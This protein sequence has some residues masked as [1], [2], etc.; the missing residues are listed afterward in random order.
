MC[1]LKSNKCLSNF[2]NRF[3]P[4]DVHHCSFKQ[5][6]VVFTLEVRKS[7]FN[8]GKMYHTRVRFKQ[9]IFMYRNAHCSS[10]EASNLQLVTAWRLP[11]DEALS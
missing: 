3:C 10:D 9:C 5:Q 8:S 2:T 1:S 11:D 6:K 7:L 4:Y